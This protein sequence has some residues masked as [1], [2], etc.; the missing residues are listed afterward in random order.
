MINDTASLAS[1]T[2]VLV[3]V[4]PDHRLQNRLQE[5]SITDASDGP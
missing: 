5:Q 3:A 1:L 4:S 2:T